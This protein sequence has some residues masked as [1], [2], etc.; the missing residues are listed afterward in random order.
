MSE[1]RPMK[2]GINGL[3]RIGKLSLWYHVSKRTFSEIVVN[4]GRQ[5][6]QGLQDITGAIGRNSAYG[7]IGAYLYEYK[8]PRVVENLDEKTNRMCV[9]GPHATVLGKGRDPGEINWQ[10]EHDVKLVVD[11]TSALRDPTDPPGDT[12]VS[13]RGHPQAGTAKVA[14]SAPFK[15]K[16]K[17]ADMPEDAFTTVMGINEDDYIPERHNL[18]S[19][20]SC[21]TTCLSFMVKPIL[22]QYFLLPRWWCTAGMTMNSAVIQIFSGKGPRQSRIP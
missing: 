7:R 22:D 6:G 16:D 21:T 4:I 12:K 20:A 9:D 17:A 11:T 10:E 3:G 5:V 2:L 14:L 19:A 8:C 15:A 13:L 1:T 18:V